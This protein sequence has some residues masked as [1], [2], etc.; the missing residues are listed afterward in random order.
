[1]QDSR[2]GAPRAVTPDDTNLGFV[3]PDSSSVL[4]SRGFEG[5]GELYPLAGGAPRLVPGLTRDDFVVRWN[6]DGRSVIVAHGLLPVRVE[7]VDVES[8]RRNLIR[9]ITP[10]PTGTL[11]AV[12]LTIANDPNAYAYFTWKQLSH[13]F[14]IQG[15]Q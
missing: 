11:A 3:S 10:E 6:P 1:M 14:L 8:G 13:L 2:T 5:V 9:I 15:A 7:R 12:G 4:V